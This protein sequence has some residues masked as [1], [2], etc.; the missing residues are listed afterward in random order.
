MLRTASRC[1]P[2]ARRST[3]S[4]TA[5]MRPAASTT[6]LQSSAGSSSAQAR[7]RRR[8]G[9]R[10]ARAGCGRGRGSRGRPAPR[11]AARR[12]SAV[13]ARLPSCR[14]AAENRCSTSA[15]MSAQT[16]AMPWG[17]GRV[18]TRLASNASCR[19]SSTASASCRRRTV[20]CTYVRR[21]PGVRPSASCSTACA[22][23]AQ[24]AA[25]SSAVSSH[26][27]RACGTRNQ[28]SSSAANVAGREC[29][30]CS[31][32]VS[33]DAAVAMPT[34]DVPATSPARNCSRSRRSPRAC[35]ARCAAACRRRRPCRHRPTGV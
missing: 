7:W 35:G 29:T 16:V 12:P 15:D 24:S 3:R 33:H 22:T 5:T 10:L 17:C 6:A 32:R 23:A 25:S 1:R 20:R 9:R 2:A 8:R 4:S 19:R 31:A 27:I 28:P 18:V 13:S 14:R 30:R 34:D 21:P 26:R 11:P